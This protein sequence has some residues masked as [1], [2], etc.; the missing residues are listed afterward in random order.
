[1]LLD[2][3]GKVRGRLLN[4]LGPFDILSKIIY[5]WRVQV[6]PKHKPYCAKDLERA[7][8]SIRDPLRVAYILG[9][10]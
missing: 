10:P 3:L 7:V 5:R 6:P 2:K 4:I 1:M 8:I 9:L